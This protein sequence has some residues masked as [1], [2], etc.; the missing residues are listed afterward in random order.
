[1]HRLA[2]YAAEM[3]NA[4][5]RVKSF[6]W[7]FNE[8]SWL[9]ILNG[10]QFKY[11]RVDAGP[12]QRAKAERALQQIATAPRQGVDPRNFTPVGPGAQSPG[13]RVAPRAP[14]R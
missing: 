10:Y 14:G 3:P 1:M 4:S 6:A 12:E 8:V 7:A 9:D 11:A 5:N 13:V 2:V